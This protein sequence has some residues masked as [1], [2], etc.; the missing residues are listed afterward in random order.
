MDTKSKWTSTSGNVDQKGGIE[1]IL[2]YNLSN[3]IKL[4]PEKTTIAKLLYD[5]GIPDTWGYVRLQSK[6]YA[7]WQTMI[8][9]HAITLNKEEVIEEIEIVET[10]PYPKAVM[11]KSGIKSLSSEDEDKRQHKLKKLFLAKKLDTEE[12]NQ[13]NLAQ[14]VFVREGTEMTSDEMQQHLAFLPEVTQQES[15][16]TEEDLDVGEDEN[17]EEEK[18]QMRDILMK[19]KHIL[20]KG[21]QMPP[22]ARGVLCNMDIKGHNPIEQRSRIVPKDLLPKYLLQILMGFAKQVTPKYYRR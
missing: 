22:A 16:I 3:Q 13:E 14:T 12:I 17:T 6:R 8:Y 2:L 1:S 19:Y 15:T 20:H 9:E 11:L 10:K 18:Q 21:G 5:E 7:Q 4:I